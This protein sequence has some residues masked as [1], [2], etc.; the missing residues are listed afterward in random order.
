M[1]HPRPGFFLV[2]GG[3]ERNVHRFLQSASVRAKKYTENYKVPEMFLSSFKF[4]DFSTIRCRTI[5][6]N[7]SKKFQDT[8][9][10]DNSL[11]AMRFVPDERLQLKITSFEI[12]MI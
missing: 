10:A 5:H 7:N 8:E 6:I 3:E 4:G 12:G 9:T 2:G 1:R 11:C